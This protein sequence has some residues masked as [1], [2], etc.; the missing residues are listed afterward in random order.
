MRKS[1]LKLL[2][3]GFLFFTTGLAQA[4]LD[5]RAFQYRT[6]VRPEY[7]NQLRLAVQGFLFSKDDEY[8][9]KIFEGRTYYGTQ[10]ATR[11]AYFPSP[12]LRLEAGIYL[13]KD[14]GNPRFM[15]VQPLF[16]AI[17]QTGPHRILLGN[18]EGHLNHNYIEPLFDFERVM[19]NRLEEG[20]QYQYT[21]RRWTVD[22]W[23]D[24]QRQQYRFSDYQER[25][26]G[27]LVADAAVVRDSSGWLVRVPFQFLA[28]HQG[29]QLDTID[30]PLTTL[31]NVASGLRVRKE[32]GRKFLHSW[33]ADFYGTYYH[34]YS[35]TRV[36]PYERGTGL[37]LNLGADTRF[38]KIQLSYWRGNGF[39]APQG[40][41]LYQSIS[42]TVNDR[43]YTERNR[44]LLILRLFSD[45]KLANGLILS[46]RLE[47]FYDFNRKEVE[48]SF[49]TY[50]NFNREFRLT[51][52][53]RESTEW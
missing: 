27:G 53:K 24:W 11:L 17:Y 1:L 16:T 41:P 28:I 51:T 22:A 48:F 37:Y 42:Y 31:F 18:I 43:N 25:I 32:V 40:G 12:K 13:W 44:H 45:Y 30:V 46:T 29:G 39:I 21:T 23:V 36:L 33:Y 3:A 14:Y 10:L 20:M 19:L 47:P 7:D 15:Q 49:G 52:L 35:F 2:V 50:L 5:N 38:T 4:Q 26:A 6:P 8:F 9:N 34:D